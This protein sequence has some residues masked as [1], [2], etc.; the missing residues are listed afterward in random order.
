MQN[1]DTPLLA[2][3][4][5]GHLAVVKM[6]IEKYQCSANEIYQVKLRNVAFFIL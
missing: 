5:N 1:G 2:A 4:Y 3:V 6:L